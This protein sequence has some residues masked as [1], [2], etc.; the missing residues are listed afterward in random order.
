[1]KQYIGSVTMALISLG[2]FSACGAQDDVTTELESAGGAL[3]DEASPASVEQLHEF[4]VEGTR[5]SIIAVDGELLTRFS[6]QAATPIDVADRGAAT[7]TRAFTA[8]AGPAGKD[9]WV[10]VIEDEAKHFPAPGAH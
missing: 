10:L 9:D 5:Y 6:R 3:T 1:M 2:L 4:D 8:P 7:A